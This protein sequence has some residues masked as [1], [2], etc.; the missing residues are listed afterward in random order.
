MKKQDNI[1]ARELNKA[2]VNN[3]PT[4]EFKVMVIKILDKTVEDLRKTLN[5]ETENKKRTDER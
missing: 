2:D 1:T 3:M 4:G 5:K